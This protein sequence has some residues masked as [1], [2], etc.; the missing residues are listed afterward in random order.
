M[1]TVKKDG[2]PFFKATYT[3]AADGKSMAETGGAVASTEK[4]K[5][6]FDRM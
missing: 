4:F 1:I 3:V 2:K 6:T 5:I